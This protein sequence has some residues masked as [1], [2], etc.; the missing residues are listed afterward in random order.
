MNQII[1]SFCN[2][3]SFDNKYQLGGHL[4]HCL[5]RKQHLIE[6][7][8]SLETGNDIIN[9]EFEYLPE[10]QEELST[11][12]TDFASDIIKEKVIIAY[13]KATNAY[14]ER[15][16]EILNTDEIAFL[17]A[18]FNK[19]IS[20]IR[21][22]AN[23]R[24]YMEICE[25]VSKC[26]GLSITESDELINLVRRISYI[27]GMEIPLPAKYNTI[28]NRIVSAVN[29]KRYRVTKTYYE[30]NK[31]MFG[32]NN[33]LGKVPCVVTDILDVI[34][35]MLV[36]EDVYPYLN[37]EYIE[38]TQ[39]CYEYNGKKRIKTMD[40]VYSEFYNSE[41][42]LNSQNEIH[43]NWG[44][45]VKPLHVFLGIDATNLTSSLSATPIYLSLGNM[46]IDNLQ[47]YNGSELIGYMPVSLA[48]K[49][50][51]MQCLQK[52]GISSIKAQEDCMSMHARWL[53]QECLN[54]ILGPIRWYVVFLYIFITF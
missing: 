12:I 9:F 25:F 21:A 3:K 40:I 32:E 13:G 52:N 34:A 14:L 2:T 47:T 37:F 24:I 15:Q 17:N 35:Q 6:T 42:F 7:C 30:H 23:I 5:D 4:R 39:I 16:R 46:N 53:D 33:D 1:C 43:R 22:K 49:A 27:N 51:Q 48:S 31:E 44:E 41:F 8:Y 18:G 11:D 38:K 10:V 36:D 20:D 45:N 26:H 28:H 19:T 54:D 29:Q 50:R